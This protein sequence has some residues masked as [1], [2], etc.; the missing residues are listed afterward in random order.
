M[1]KYFEGAAVIALVM[2]T[3]QVA[4]AADAPAA[5]DNTSLDQ[6]V[7]T[8][9]KRETNLQN[10]PIAIS[11]LSAEAM[12]DR[13]AES[14]ISLMDGAIPSLRVAT[15][16]ARQS[17]LTVGIRGIVPFDANQTARDQGVG[18]YIDGVYL[19]RQ[20]GLNVALLDTGARRSA[21]R[22]ARHAVRP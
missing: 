15:F 9:T 11:V 22:P 3:A 21:A 13:H 1:R 8:A 6:V 14:L 12:A 20:Q 16:E 7:I 19:G 4:Y 10:T 17:A 18:V 5:S 2:A